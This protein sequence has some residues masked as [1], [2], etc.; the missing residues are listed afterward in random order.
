MTLDDQ[1]RR[2]DPMVRRGFRAQLRSGS[3]LTGQLYVA[4]DFIKDVPPAHIDWRTTPPTLPTA[5]ASL[6]SLQDSLASVAKKL[7]AIPYDQLAQDLHRDLGDL[8][9]SLKHVDALVQHLDTGVVPEAQKTLADARKAVDD[10]RKTLGTVDQTVGPQATNALNEVS[11]AA[12]SLRGL[13]NYLERHP[14]SL[15]KGKPEDPK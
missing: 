10:L 9:T 13:A 8:D 1:R 14:E 4:L 12:A 15:L 6:D 3:L 2:I 11:K 5:P 7:D